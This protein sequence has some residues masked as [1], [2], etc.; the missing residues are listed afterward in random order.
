MLQANK[1]DESLKLKVT[2]VGWYSAILCIN[3]ARWLT[4]NSYENNK[5][6]F[7]DLRDIYAYLWLWP[8]AT[9]K[10]AIPLSQKDGTQPSSCK[11]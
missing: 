9:L 8:Q 1:T 3:Q 6:G 2:S 10:P 5:I 4:P 11:S 7:N